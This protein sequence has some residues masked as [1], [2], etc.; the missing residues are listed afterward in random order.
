MKNILES[1]ETFESYARID[2]C[3]YRISQIYKNDKKLTPIDKMIYQATGYDKKKESE[4]IDL[5][6]EIINSKKLIDADYS[7]DEKTLNEILNIK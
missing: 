4:I 7:G 3:Y 1:P 2:Y 5:L 6:K